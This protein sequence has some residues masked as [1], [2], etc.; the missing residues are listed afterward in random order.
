MTS[1][2]RERSTV[3]E[4]SRLDQIPPKRKELIWLTAPDGKFALDTTEF[5]RK[6]N[7]YR[8][9]IR[10]GILHV[11]VNGRI[12]D[13]SGIHPGDSVLLYAVG[14]GGFKYIMEEPR[15]TFRL[16]R[17]EEG[18]RY[19]RFWLQGKLCDACLPRWTAEQLIQ[20]V[21][22]RSGY[23]DLKLWRDQ[24][25]VEGA[26]GWDED[27]LRM[28]QGRELPPD[29]PGLWRWEI[30][31]DHRQI[32][33]VSPERPIADVKISIQRQCEIPRTIFLKTRSQY[34]D[35]EHE[36]MKN[37]CTN[38]MTI[39]V[40]TEPAIQEDLKMVIWMTVS[41]LPFRSGGTFRTNELDS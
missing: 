6:F 40:S 23:R 26:I 18:A 17:L 31:W 21:T 37:E 11:K 14:P 19:V 36:V 24:E 28:T 39:R 35:I 1:N 41:E 12:S 32:M 3:P 5:N 4:D 22:E 9:A 34:T 25:P 33:L 2:V 29:Y 7:E 8:S 10:K 20:M 38:G 16:E 13:G 15:P 27:L 30:E